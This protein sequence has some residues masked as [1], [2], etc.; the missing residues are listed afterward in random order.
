MTKLLTIL[1]V[2]TSS[3]RL[4]GKCLAE[5]KS[6][7][8]GQSRKMSAP[9]VVWIARR[10]R[11]M[12]TRLVAATTTDSSDDQLAEVLQAEG[13]EVV[14]GS[15]DDVIG[16]MDTVVQRYGETTHVLRMLGD[17]P[18]PATELIEY[19][20]KRLGE[21]GKDA[22]VWALDSEVWPLYGCREFSYS[23]RAWQ[24]IAKESA[25]R[26]H[27]DE[28]FHKNRKAF[29][30]LFHLPPE[31]FYF[32]Q[33]YR[34]EVDHERD[35]EMVRAVADEV[36]MLAPVK[37]IV[38]FLDTHPDIAKINSG[39]AEKT[40]PLSL[41]TYSNSQRRAWLMGLVNQKIM[42][43]QGEWITPPGDGAFPVFCRCGNLLGHGWEAK[44]Y[45]RDRAVIL[46]NGFV[47]CPNCMAVKEWREEIPRGRRI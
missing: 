19:S 23:I 43:W 47:R 36:G 24:K 31:N 4:P 44:L 18:W 14:R 37:E 2:R 39:Y 42:T 27:P 25:F 38:R 15:K 16:R 29:D 26:E 32:R 9:L 11:Q 40:G 12:N 6:K 46:K 13:V 30:V 5:V 28:Y 7:V 21:T 22:F 8:P 20:T 1:T 33:S 35:L 34:T 45:T 17:M 10:L 3:E 41:N